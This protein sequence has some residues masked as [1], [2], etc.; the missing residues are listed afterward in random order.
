MPTARSQSI[1]LVLHGLSVVLLLIL[2]SQSFRTPPSP[3]TPKPAHSI[4]LAPPRFVVHV[5]EDRGGGSNTSAAPARRGIPPPRSFRTFIPPQSHPDPKLAMMPTIDFD[6]PV[7]DVG[8]AKF[9]DPLSKFADGGF[10]NK[11]GHTI[12]NNPNGPGIGDERGPNRSGRFGV[13]MKPAELIYRVDPEFSEEARKARFQGVVVLMI[14]VGTDGRAHNPKV[15]ETAGLGL[16]EKAIEA[17][18][19]WRFRPAQRGGTPLMST[20]RV[21]VHFHLM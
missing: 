10:G 5:T 15:I 16:D 18:Q 8:T 6:V 3:T 20:A 21:E 9:G 2:T 17:V 14:E 13:P 12:G 19:Q 7:I 11:G 1:S 4:L